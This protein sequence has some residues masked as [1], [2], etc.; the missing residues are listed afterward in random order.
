MDNF[1]QIINK[2]KYQFKL[3]D[4]SALLIAA[5]I[6]LPLISFTKEGLNLIISGKFSLGI[7]GREEILGSFKMLILTSIFGGSLGI[8]NGWLLSNCEFP[9]RKFL[10]ICQLVPLAAPAYLT[11]AILQ[12][13]GSI[14]GFQISGMWWGVLILSIATYPYTFILTNESFNKFGIKG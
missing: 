11:T 10:R 2:S 7:T 9:F 1:S 13:A 8:I 6:L 5:V 4:L 3:I 12:D 14:M